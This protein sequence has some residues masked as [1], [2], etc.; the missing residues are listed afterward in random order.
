MY[1]ISHIFEVDG[2]MYALDFR[3]LIFCLLDDN[4][5]NFLNKIL[6]DEA[7]G[8]SFDNSSAIIEELIQN[9][10]F[11][12][13][14]SEN[15]IQLPDY[16][17]LNISFAPVHD[18]N[19][20]CK[21]CYAKG[22]EGTPNYQDHFDKS[23]IDNLLDYIYVRKY[24]NYPAYKFD[25]VSGG[26]PL[27]DFSIL[28]YFLS[29]MRQMDRLHDKQTTVLIVTNGTLLNEQR[30]HALDQH[31]VFLG[32]SIDGP[33]SVHNRHRVYKSGAP[34]YQDVA[35]GIMLLRS[36]NATSK[37][38]DA[39]A[40]AVI[41][42][43]TGS[44]VDVMETCISL[45][46]K[47]M[48]MQLLRVPR[49]HPLSFRDDDISQLKGQYVALIAHIISFVEKGDLSRLKMIAND[50]D[51]FGKF[52]RRLLLHSPVYYRCFAGKNKIAITAN[53]EIYPCDSFCGE[54]S[55][56]MGSIDGRLDNEI[57]A[58]EFQQAHFQNRSKCA[59]CWARQICG[60]D[61]YYNSYMINGDI[62]EPDPIVCEM[63]RFFIE[64]TI[65]MLLKIKSINS[66]YLS[67]LASF[68]NRR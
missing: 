9:D 25:F 48:Q 54:N 3:H 10:Y 61:C 26:E 4:T 15:K 20:S 33:E 35:R 62:H 52:I 50:N 40:M 39:W 24:S 2:K 31:D 43:D 63:N 19:F 51:S 12:S 5:Y 42:R 46:F 6:S 28:E 29:K 21:Y 22:G 67:Y 59:Q 34:T 11:V 38:K 66:S 44:L 13:K 57:I 37:I 8:K 47:R 7:E 60:G 17:I 32:I 23:K 68:L 58:N 55:F 30:I 41:A 45:G 53:G 56:C 49:N 18:C 27:L 64:R 36:S 16:D 65:D 14:Y 1:K